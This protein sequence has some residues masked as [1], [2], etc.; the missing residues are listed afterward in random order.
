MIAHTVKQGTPEW[1]KLRSGIPTASCLHKILTPTGKA[2]SQADGYLAQLAA[3]WFLGEPI[4]EK[5]SQFMDRGTGMEP[6][7]RVWYSFET[8]RNVV[9]VGFC[10]TDDGKAGCSP[11]GLVDEDGGLEIKCPGAA[12]QM[13]YFLNGVEKEYRVQVQGNLWI[14][15]RKWWQLLVY[16]PYLPKAMPVFERDDKYIWL[17]AEAV[18]EFNARLDM[19]RARLADR[20]ADYDAM[21]EAEA[22]ASDHPF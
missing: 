9:E 19:A 13:D 15:G 1:L 5:S 16:N 14:T 17:L 8:D 22:L 4:E 21:R 7:A 20:K 10:T 3:E 6:E 2:S 12:T 18:G 11:D